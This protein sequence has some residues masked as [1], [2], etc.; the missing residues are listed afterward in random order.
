MISAIDELP[1]E[2]ELPVLSKKAAVQRL[3]DKG[4]YWP[5]QHMDPDFGELL[6]DK[7]RNT[8]NKP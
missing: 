7:L 1:A 3:I 2:D 8:R 6:D 5:G 4:Y